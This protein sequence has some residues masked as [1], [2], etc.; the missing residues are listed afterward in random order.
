[1]TNFIVNIA[2]GAYEDVKAA[3]EAVGHALQPVEATVVADIKADV[4]VLT[5]WGAQFLTDEGKIALQDAETYGPQ[6]LSG[7]ITITAAFGLLSADLVAKGVADIENLGDL[8][9]NAL[10]TQTNAAASALAAAPVV[11]ADAVTPAVEV[12]ETPTVVS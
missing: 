8:L 10:R 5:A 9:F 11:A 6:I 3:V 4:P 12:V 2:D 1:M 7:Q